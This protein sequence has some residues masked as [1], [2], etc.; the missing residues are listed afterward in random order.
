MIDDRYLKD[1]EKFLE[2]C[3]DV[4]KTY[5][6]TRDSLEEFFSA[7]PSEEK[8]NSF[9]RVT[10]FFKFLVKEGRFTVPDYE[11]ADYFDI[12]YRFVAL[13]SLI[14]ALE[15]DVPFQEFQGWVHEKRQ[16]VFPI[17]LN[18]FE[19]LIDQ[20]KQ[21]M[22]LL[23]KTV[24]FFSSL[25]SRSKKYIENRIS[26]NG[27]EQPIERLAKQLYGIRSQFVHEARLVTEISGI[28][29]IST[30]SK[31]TLMIT[32]DLSELILIFERGLLLHFGF[33][34]IQLPQ[35]NLAVDYKSFYM[36]EKNADA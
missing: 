36:P 11:K 29:T 22:G 18:Q 10:S 2:Y 6:P 35:L 19:N 34:E 27:K 31:K 28:T 15:S 1:K 23:R 4:L 25:D 24:R 17:D 12:T 3:F 30:R 7:I 33:S 16:S 5:F 14:E 9:L 26:V 21:E 32:L 13:I 8:K 20:Y